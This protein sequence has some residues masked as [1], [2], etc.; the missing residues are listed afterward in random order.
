MDP[1]MNKNTNTKLTGWKLVE[2]QYFLG[3]EL[4][5]GSYGFVK[6]AIHKKTNLRVAIK[7]VPK[8]FMDNIDTKRI[9]R[10]IDLLSS[11]RNEFVVELLDILYE[12]KNPDFDTVFLVFE[13]APCDLKKLFFTPCFIK[14]EDIEKIIYKILCG[15]Y[16][17]HSCSVLHRDLKPSNILLQDNYAIK[18]CD[19]GLARSVLSECDY[20]ENIVNNNNN[21]VPMKE[22][23]I[24]NNTE[25]AKTQPKKGVMKFMKKKPTAEPIPANNINDSNL[26]DDPKKPKSMKQVLSHHVVTRWYRAPELILIQNNYTSTID[27]WSLGCIFGELMTLLKDNC[28]NPYERKP[29]FPGKSCFPLSPPKDQST[30]IKTNHGYPV[31]SRDQLNVI[32]DVI[33]APM[34]EDIEFITDQHAKDYLR[35]FEKKNKKNLKERFSGSSD[36]SLDLLCRMIE[37]NPNKRITIR[38]CFEHP[39]FRNVRDTSK[40]KTSNNILNLD[41]ENLELSFEQLKMKFVEVINNFKIKQRGSLIVSAGSSEISNTTTGAGSMDVEMNIEN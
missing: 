37:F 30:I 5:N 28:V 27:I 24:N 26:T 31:D 4:G 21:N 23:G 34:E 15:L 9:L 39:F 40:E 13:W 3:D 35:S 33:G 20:P 14:N 38:E 17:I 29:L 41:Y 36:E 19:F 12:E 1:N 32:F 16:Y 25:P 22:E 7:M 11:I 10:E 6:E 2:E 18:I 8:L